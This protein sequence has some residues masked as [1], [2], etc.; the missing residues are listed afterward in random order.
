MRLRVHLPS[1]P[2]VC[3]AEAADGF[4]FVPFS[5]RPSLLLYN[6]L[7]TQDYKYSTLHYIVACVLC[8]AASS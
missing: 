2:A 7:S 8:R 3:A 1:C 6:I 4:V 5:S